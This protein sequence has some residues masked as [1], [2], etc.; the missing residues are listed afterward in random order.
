MKQCENCG[1]YL[2]PEEICDCKKQGEKKP[3]DPAKSGDEPKEHTKQHKYI[4]AQEGEKV[5]ASF[6]EPGPPK[7]GAFWGRG[8]A[9]ER[10][11]RGR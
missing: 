7:S 8:G 9:R 5:K 10:L 1:A 2:D 6:G 4:I 11:R 3:P